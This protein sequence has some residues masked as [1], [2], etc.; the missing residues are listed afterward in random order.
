MSKKKRTKRAAPQRKPATQNNPNVVNTSDSNV[1]KT[2]S[3]P[4]TRKRPT[5]PKQRKRSKTTF[6][7]KD[8]LFGRENYMMMIGGL[9]LIVLGMILMSGGG[10]DDPNTWDASRIYSPVRITLAPIVILLG[11]I[12]EILAIFRRP[13]AVVE[14]TEE[15]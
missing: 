13:K 12:V 11:L 4:A 6:T 10:M 15:T 9:V 5:S 14:A 1:V 8:M 3:K 2:S 7:S